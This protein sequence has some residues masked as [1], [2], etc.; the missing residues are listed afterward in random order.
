MRRWPF[1]L[2]GLGV[3]LGLGFFGVYGADTRLAGAGN[4]VELV[5]EGPGR[6]RNGEFFEM[7][8]SVA[9]KRDIS[10]LV[11]LIDADLWREVTV[12]TLLPDPSGHG[13]RRNAFEF[14][15]GALNA[16]ESLLIKVDGQ[17][18]PSLTLS[19]HEGPISVADGDAVLTAVTYAMEVLP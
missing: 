16:G 19:A 17:I 1:S 11:V 18:N 5:V 9:T 12:N 10:D 14:R 13:F 15:F 2:G 6:I 7:I 3:L 8:L 4:S